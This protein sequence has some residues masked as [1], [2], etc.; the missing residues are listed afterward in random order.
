[1]SS[2]IQMRRALYEQ[3]M[4]DDY[5]DFVFGVGVAAIILER[6][7]VATPF[8]EI[9]ATCASLTIHFSDTASKGLFQIRQ[10]FFNASKAWAYQYIQMNYNSDYTFTITAGQYAYIRAT[11]DCDYLDEAYIKDN[12]NNTYLWKG[13]NVT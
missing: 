1:M 10:Q 3:K 5:P 7:L 11:L 13:K 2:L 4:Q 6:C 8:I 9:P 12:T